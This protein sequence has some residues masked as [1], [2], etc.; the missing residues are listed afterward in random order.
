[1]TDSLVRNKRLTPE[2]KKAKLDALRRR[3]QTDYVEVA[4]LPTWVKLAITKRELYGTEYGDL[5]KEFNRNGQTIS[6]YHNSPAGK[7][8]RAEIQRMIAEP[9]QLAQWLIQSEQAGQ[10]LRY[11]ALAD[12][13]ENT[14]DFALAERI[15]RTVLQ[16]GGGLAPP[17]KEQERRPVI[18]LNL[19]GTPATLI[20]EAVEV[21]SESRLLKRGD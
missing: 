17:K 5:E 15:R 4:Q 19:P 13:A 10:A 14:G 18:V 16:S 11:I 7:K 20:G 2:E 9:E 8:L 12:A 3:K 6:K 1:M 21:I